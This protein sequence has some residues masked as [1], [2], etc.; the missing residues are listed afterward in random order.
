[1]LAAGGFASAWRKYRW[2]AQSGPTSLRASARGSRTRPSSTSRR[3]SRRIRSASSSAE[4]PVARSSRGT[5]RRERVERLP[6]AVSGRARAFTRGGS[7]PQLD[8]IRWPPRRRASAERR[9]GSAIGTR[10]WD[11]RPQSIS[12]PDPASATLSPE[13]PA[14]GSPAGG[15]KGI[16]SDAKTPVLVLR[17]RSYGLGQSAASL[18]SLWHARDAARDRPGRRLGE[19]DHDVRPPVSGDPRGR[20]RGLGRP[21]SGETPRPS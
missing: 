14:T 5:H 20:P 21:A 9:Q 2:N 3:Y 17:T 7:L 6:G 16:G 11:G 13:R 8:L 18:S 10:L 12:R 4:R 15:A 1:M 19:H